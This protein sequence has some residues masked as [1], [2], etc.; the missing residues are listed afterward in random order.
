LRQLLV[1]EK[2]LGN[3]K[4]VKQMTAVFSYY[5]SLKICFALSNEY[6]SIE[7]KQISWIGNGKLWLVIYF[8]H[9]GII[10]ILFFID[11]FI[12]VFFENRNHFGLYYWNWF[13]IE[14]PEMWIYDHYMDIRLCISRFHLHNDLDWWTPIIL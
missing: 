4:F 8:M 12:F 7:D 11:I 3:I 1:E 10:E 14:E 5:F 6:L 9:T 2:R 13:Y